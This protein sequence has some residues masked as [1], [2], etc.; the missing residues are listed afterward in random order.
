MRRA[1]FLFFCTTTTG[2]YNITTLDHI[3]A[4]S[5]SLF[6]PFHPSHSI[7]PPPLPFPSLP[8]SPL[9]PLFSP[10]A[11]GQL[12]HGLRFLFF[13]S[14]QIGSFSIPFPIPP[15]F[16]PLK[17]SGRGWMGQNVQL[18]LFFARQGFVSTHHFISVRY[19]SL[20]ICGPRGGGVWEGGRG[21][22][23]LG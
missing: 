16:S 3:I 4:I 9:P 5:I 23:Y 21:R 8:F 15:C 10:G 13:F 2:D 14:I 12:R 22:F 19:I 18:P 17:Q 1:M 7:Q 11:F 6:L 20:P